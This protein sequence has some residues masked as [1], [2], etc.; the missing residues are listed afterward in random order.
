MITMPAGLMAFK[1][2]YRGADGVEKEVVVHAYDEQT[3]RYRANH[4]GA[5]PSLESII[6]VWRI[7]PIN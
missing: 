4:E 2:M 6:R 3:A 7:D 5:V 1:V